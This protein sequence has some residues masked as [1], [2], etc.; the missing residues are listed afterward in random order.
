[1]PI[2]VS[3]RKSLSQNTLKSPETY[4]STPPCHQHYFYNGMIKCLVISKIT[5]KSHFATQTLYNK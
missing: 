2:T 4:N 1:M 5:L 3:S